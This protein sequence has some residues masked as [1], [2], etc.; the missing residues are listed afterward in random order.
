MHVCIRVMT[1]SRIE[2]YA[3]LWEPG[4]ID[5]RFQKR[6]EKGKEKKEGTKKLSLL[7]HTF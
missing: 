6:E 5:L 3:S 1:F 4:H 7:S 2:L